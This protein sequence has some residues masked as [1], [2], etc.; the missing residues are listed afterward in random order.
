MSENTDTTSGLSQK[1]TDIKQRILNFYTYCSTGV[2]RDTRR[3]WKVEAVKIINISLRSFLDRD[4]QSQACAMTFR[5]L[6]AVVPA[7]ALLL[8]IGRGFG[9]Q[10]LLQN[11][12]Y[13]YFPSQHVALSAAF[14]FVDSYL[15]Q[16]SEGVFVG[17]GIVFLLWTLI[18]LLMS[19]EESFNTIWKVQG[20]SII[21]KVSDYISILLVLP[22]LMICSAGLTLLM[23]STLQHFI[24]V[25]FLRPAIDW[26]LDLGSL[27]FTAFFFCGAY[28]LIPNTRVK[29][30]NAFIVGF[31]VAIAFQILQ[32]LF[33]SGQMYVTRYNAIYGSFS[34]LPL[35]LIWLQLVWLI[36]LIGCLLCYALQNVGLYNYYLDVKNISLSYHR[37]VI[38]GVMAI[39]AKRFHQDMPP[40]TSTEL[41]KNYGLPMSLVNK[42]IP[43]LHEAGLISYLKPSD[44]TDECPV[45]PALDV[46]TLTCGEI[47]KRMQNVGSSEFI[48]D[49]E[50]K[51]EA[52]NSVCT[53]I[54]EAM[55]DVADNIK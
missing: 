45:Q 34:F 25:D 1:L 24:H 40:L 46:S 18:S 16:A 53:R 38:M 31:V 17:V 12:L 52:S 14:K 28:M 44:N 37:K 23:S 29:F 39:I 51:F 21:R 27:I 13:S 5:T 33:V 10:D 47:I 50:E 3:T 55:T 8:A 35:F 9:F 54:T 4:L 48:P 32:W 42:I 7:L 20:R 6:L 30:L 36:T 49:F 43:D 41:S 2:W 11:Q 22:V 26:V 19:V 15:N